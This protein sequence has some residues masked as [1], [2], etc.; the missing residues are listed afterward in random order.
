MEN[1]ALKAQER[2]D[3]RPAIRSPRS[4]TNPCECRF[5]EAVVHVKKGNQYL[6]N[7]CFNGIYQIEVT[8]L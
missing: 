2:F 8:V 5:A 7:S 3:N 1:L 4:F 6:C